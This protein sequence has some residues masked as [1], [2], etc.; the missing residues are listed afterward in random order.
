MGKRLALL[1]QRAA[2]EYFNSERMEQKAK[3]TKRA[4]RG[5]I[6]RIIKIAK[7]T[8]GET[9]PEI[10]GFY[11]KAL[12]EEGFKDRTIGRNYASFNNLVK[13]IRNYREL[14]SQTM[15]DTTNL[16][17]IRK[18]FDHPALVDNDRMADFVG[19]V[20]DGMGEKYLVD[21]RGNHG[22]RDVM[23]V[24]FAA[25]EGLKNGSI[26]ELSMGSV[27]EGVLCASG[28]REARMLS[29]YV[30]NFYDDLF[31][32]SLKEF[33]KRKEIH[34]DD[35]TPLFMNKFSKNQGN[36]IATRNIARIVE[37]MEHGVTGSMLVAYARNR[38][39]RQHLYA[40]NVQFGNFAGLDP[41]AARLWMREYK[42]HT[43]GP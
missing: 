36:R 12:R 39:L 35:Y 8:S 27:T 9:L 17:H 4:E 19:N 15:A 20:V 16:L 38:Y 26:Y 37:K 28:R 40:N 29:D 14:S 7:N 25:Y 13:H 41:R 24:L 18:D 5:D 22:L 6:E 43:K 30:G 1:L 11:V 2:K 23:V 31:M 21:R 10:V 3:T 42:K 33:A 32:P 34:L